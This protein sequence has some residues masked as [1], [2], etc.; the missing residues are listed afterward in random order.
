MLTK[1]RLFQL[2]EF[3]KILFLDSDNL[4]TRPMD[5]IFD[6]PAAQVLKNKGATTEEEAPEDEGTQPTEYMFAG[7]AGAGGFNHSTTWPPP[8]NERK[9]NAGCVVFHPSE[10]LYEYYLGIAGLK[11]RF[12]GRFPEQSLWAYAHR[13]EGNLPWKQLGHM[14]NINRVVWSDVEHGVA[15]LHVKWWSSKIDPRLKDLAMRI[16]GRMEGFWEGKEGHKF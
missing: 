12:N 6:D 5:G 3:E 2:T 10:E 9:L 1:L 7:N 16:R 15:S 11:N 8:T 4:L 14:W 13:K